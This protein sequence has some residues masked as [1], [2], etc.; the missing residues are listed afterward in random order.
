MRRSAEQDVTQLEE[1]VKQS[2][3]EA[4][5]IPIEVKQTDAVESVPKQEPSVP[6]QEPEK[7][8]EK[9]YVPKTRIAMITG[10]NG[11]E[12]CGSQK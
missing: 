4:A 9:K 6:K 8:D 12:F 7:K 10:Y 2:Q 3:I 1:E 11:S 5:I